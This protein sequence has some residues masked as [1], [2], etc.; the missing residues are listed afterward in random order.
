MQS[1]NMDLVWLL[2]QPVEAYFPVYGHLFLRA[3]TILTYG[4]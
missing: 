1:L 3:A 4:V 2:V